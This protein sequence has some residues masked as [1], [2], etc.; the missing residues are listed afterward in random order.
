MGKQCTSTEMA[1]RLATKDKAQER[2]A[3][4][5]EED[6]RVKRVS[7][8][9]DEERRGQ[10]AELEQAPH[11]R[12][13]HA[14]TNDFSNCT[15]NGV[16]TAHCRRPGSAATSQARARLYTYA[17]RFEALLL[18]V[19]CNWSRSLPTTTCRR[20]MRSGEQSAM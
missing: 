6:L 16:T 17:S 4:A 1:P 8:R 14:Q 2:R 9:P 18:L 7:D 11:V 13:L 5:P 3:A 19:V 15:D 20:D 10:A 12:H